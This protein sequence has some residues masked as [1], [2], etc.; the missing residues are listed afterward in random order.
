MAWQETFVEHPMRPLQCGV[1]H[2]LVG[3]T[4]LSFLLDIFR[5][6]NAQNC[7]CGTVAGI[8]AMT[9]TTFLKK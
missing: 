9:F 6:L 8:N 4:S 2:H 7:Q 1:W 5:V 3:T